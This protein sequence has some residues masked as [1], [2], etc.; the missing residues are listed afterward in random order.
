[1]LTNEILHISKQYRI[2][3]VTYSKLVCKLVTYCCY[4][5]LVLHFC[6]VA[7]L[8][9]TTGC[10]NCMYMQIVKFLGALTKVFLPIS[11]RLYVTTHSVC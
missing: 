3:N 5:L 10:F 11:M 9:Y 8:C 7:M 6:F 4:Y 2:I 1:M